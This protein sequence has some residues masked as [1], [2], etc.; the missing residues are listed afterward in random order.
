MCVCVSVLWFVFF[1]FDWISTFIAYLM[2]KPLLQKN[3]SVNIKLITGAIRLFILLPD[4]NC[5]KGKSKTN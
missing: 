3:C 1:I 2:L 5:L 4:G